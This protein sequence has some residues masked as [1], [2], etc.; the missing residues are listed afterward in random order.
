M[1]FTATAVAPAGMFAG[2]PS[3]RRTAAP[4]IGT[5]SVPFAGT[6]A[7]GTPIA[8]RVSMKRF[9]VVPTNAAVLTSPPA[10]HP[11]MSTRRW[12]AWLE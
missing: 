5:R 7:L 4:A 9:G 12:L 11:A 3:V 1:T 2:E 6:L 8:L 10:N